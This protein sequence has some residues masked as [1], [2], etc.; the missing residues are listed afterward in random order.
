MIG[1][2]APAVV[3]AAVA[4]SM[5]RELRPARDALLA[6]GLLDADG[7]RFAHN[8]IALGDRRRPARAATASGCT[9]RRPAR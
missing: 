6:A 9:A 5:S 4:G 3:V 2:A 8:L 1:D 7:K